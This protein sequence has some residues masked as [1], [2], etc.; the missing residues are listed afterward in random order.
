MIVYV[1]CMIRAIMLAD[2]LCLLHGL[3]ASQ[4]SETLGPDDLA[5]AAGPR[6]E[7]RLQGGHNGEETTAWRLG[8]LMSM[9]SCMMELDSKALQKTPSRWWW[10]WW[11]RLVYPN[12]VVGSGWCRQRGWVCP[13][14][15]HRAS[16]P[17]PD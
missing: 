7:A 10:W 4:C 8:G 16:S 6:G 14:L 3:W 15:T 12:G 5:P 9:M 1:C 2:S 13:P 11:Q 17:S